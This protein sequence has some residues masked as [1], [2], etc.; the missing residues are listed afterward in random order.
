[1]KNMVLALSTVLLLSMACTKRPVATKPPPQPPPGPGEVHVRIKDV[2]NTGIQIDVTPWTVE[3]EADQDI[4]WTL[5]EV[6]NLQVT[7]FWVRGI[8][9]QLPNR[10]DTSQAMTIVRG[11]FLI[12]PSDPGQVDRYELRMDVNGRMMALDPGYRVKP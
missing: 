4:T 11:P 8:G 7:A 9:R 12:H 3:V 1:M 10:K 5:M 2:P 6:G